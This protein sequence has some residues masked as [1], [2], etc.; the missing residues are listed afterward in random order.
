MYCFCLS[1][2]Q[3]YMCYAT[4]GGRLNELC[5]TLHSQPVLSIIRYSALTRQKLVG[6]SW[7]PILNDPELET[8]LSIGLRM[9]CKELLR[10]RGP[11]LV[12]IYDI[13][14]TIYLLEITIN[15]IAAWFFKF[16]NF[17]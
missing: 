6:F 12:Y 1:F 13:P 7:V 9:N 4:K 16:S 17:H 10:L 14:Y 3:T 2:V 11:L 8:K 5:N 15:C